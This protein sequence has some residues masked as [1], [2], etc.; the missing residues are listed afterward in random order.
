MKLL[1]LHNSEGLTVV[2]HDF[3]PEVLT[4]DYE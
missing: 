4:E 2:K 1:T 3:Y